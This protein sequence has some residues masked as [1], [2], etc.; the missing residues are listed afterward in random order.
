[1]YKSKKRSTGET[2][3]LGDP[4]GLRSQ[5]CAPLHSLSHVVCIKPLLKGG[6]EGKVTREYGSAAWASPRNGDV[7][8]E[9]IAPFKRMA[10]RCVQH[11]SSTRRVH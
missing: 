11:L 4:E 2:G 6:W 10:L 8:A 5:S 1:M 9:T 7:S 3:P